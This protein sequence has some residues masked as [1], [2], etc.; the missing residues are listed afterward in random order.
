M[1]DI[2]LML[3]ANVFAAGF[4]LGL[5]SFLVAHLGF[6]RALTTDSKLFARPAVFAGIGLVGALNLPILWP[7]LSADLRIPVVAYVACLLTM[8]SQAIARHLSLQTPA[9]RMAAIGA[10]FFSC[11]PI[12]CWRMTVSAR[13]CPS[14]HC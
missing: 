1:G 4:I 5:A 2:F 3:P 8:T 11:C 9:S 12:P 10:A 14:P 6:L 7:G 13:R